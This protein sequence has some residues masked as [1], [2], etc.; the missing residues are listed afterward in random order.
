[1]NLAGYIRDVPD[2]PQ[3]GI[4]FKDIAPL[5]RDPAALAETVAR[6]AK[7]AP[8]CDAVAALE[9]RGFLFGAPLALALGKPFVLVR[10]AGKLPGALHVESYALE[11]GD[12]T[13]ELQRDSFPSGARVLIVDD[14]LA[15][16]GTAAAA[17]RLIERAG[18]VAAGF[19]F[20]LELEFLHGREK[21]DQTPAVSLLQY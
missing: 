8:A 21:L 9:S 1:L 20:L 5:L 11:Y 4:I 18:G 3:P 7:S 16:G 12:A 6:M 10:K 14:V 13:I 17:A 19:V 2:F 15:T